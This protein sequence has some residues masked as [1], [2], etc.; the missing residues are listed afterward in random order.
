M[1]GKA[2]AVSPGCTEAFSIW[3]IPCTLLG[4]SG[5]F[6]WLSLSPSVRGQLY[7]PTTHPSFSW[8]LGKTWVN[9]IKNMPRNMQ[10][11][12]GPPWG[13]WHH[14]CPPFTCRPA[15]LSPHLK[16]DPLGTIVS[17]HLEHSS[18]LMTPAQW[19][20]VLIPLLPGPYGLTQITLLMPGYSSWKQWTRFIEQI[21]APPWR[22]TY[23]LPFTAPSLQYLSLW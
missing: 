19:P 8:V 15:W 3:S 2:K 7:I 23:T 10:K 16:Q 11:Q 4:D 18:V 9:T 21:N 1:P 13:C 6:S 17:I 20:G 5:I 22:R 12:Q 14:P